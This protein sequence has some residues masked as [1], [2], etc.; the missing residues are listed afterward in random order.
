MS[1][2]KP[3]QVRE[4][5]ESFIVEELEINRARN[6]GDELGSDEPSSGTGAFLQVMTRAVNARNIVELGTGTGVGTLWLAADLEEHATL[7]SIDSEAEHIQLAR[8]ACEEM[9]I[10]SQ[11]V[12]LIHGAPHDIFRKL[13]DGGYDMVVVREYSDDG[14]EF[15]EQ[16]HRVLRSGG[17]CVLVHALHGGKV[18]DLAQRDEITVA[19]RE[20]LRN[21]RADRQRWSCSLV[22][23]GDGLFVAVKR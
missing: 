5:I 22:G 4:F 3:E 20:L 15:I 18:A 21:L 13:T 14:M 11:R 16:A 12:R 6:R 7:T 10:S 19:R 2:D 8:E 23:L 9:E 17:I 1:V